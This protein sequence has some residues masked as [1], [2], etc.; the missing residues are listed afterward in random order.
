MDAP[1]WSVLEKLILAQAVY[2]LGED[3][4]AQI[5]RRLRQHP[6]LKHREPDYYSQKVCEDHPWKARHANWTILELLFT[7]LHYAQGSRGRK[8]R[9]DRTT[10]RNNLTRVLDDRIRP[11]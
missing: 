10:I 1:E 8:V 3:N 9:P 11:R 4:W 5:A 6:M 2:K 7:V